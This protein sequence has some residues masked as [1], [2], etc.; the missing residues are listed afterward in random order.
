MNPSV[1]LVDD[2]PGTLD[3]VGLL[4]RSS[5][6]DVD[7]A[8]AP[9]EALRLLRERDYAYAIVDYVMPEMSGVALLEVARSLRPSLRCFVLSGHGRPSGFDASVGWF[10][11]PVD[12]DVLVDALRGA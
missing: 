3:V 2:D 4:L 9:A 1:L 7:A 6:F 8:T 11:K 10:E 5:G 12:I